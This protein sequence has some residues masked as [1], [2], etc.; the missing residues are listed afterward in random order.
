LA[1]DFQAGHAYD[2]HGDAGDDDGHASAKQRAA[3]PKS[4]ALSQLD[5]W[6]HR[7]DDPILAHM[8]LYVYSIWV[9]RVEKSTFYA[10]NA[11]SEP[12]NPRYVDIPFDPSH[13]ACAT[14]VQR[15]SR[16]P[17]VPKLGG[18]QF[19]SDA[20]AEVHYRFLP[21]LLRPLN[22]APLAECSSRQD[23]YVTTYKQLCT[24]PPG[25]ESWPA[26]RISDAE[27]GPFQRGWESFIAEQKLIATKARGSAW[28]VRTAPNLWRTE[29]VARRLQELGSSDAKAGEM[30]V[31][32]DC[33][34][35]EYCAYETVRT[36]EHF[37]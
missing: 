22:L 30:N 15:L 7:G 3:G 5:D 1:N 6:L 21:I 37:S 33:N 35:R 13:P 31:V 12:R 17:R 28:S 24:A 8:N 19:V 14:F 32:A 9:Y 23:R 36:A 20:N 27:L 4:V 10:S 2:D 18:M 34:A 11:S 26:Q 16:E 29:E 25:S